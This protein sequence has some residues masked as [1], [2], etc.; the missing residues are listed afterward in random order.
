MITDLDVIVKEWAYKVHD[1][2][3][4]PK[5]DNHIYVLSNLLYELKWPFD[6]IQEL[7][8]NL[9]EEEVKFDKKEIPLLRNLGINKSVPDEDLA[10]IING[11]VNLSGVSC[12]KGPGTT[13]FDDESYNESKLKKILNDG[14]KF[15]LTFAGTE[16]N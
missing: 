7:L 11:K 4:N 15:T 10:D 14:S 3:P 2:K 9:T 13:A 12:L 5:N 1:G 8:H 6:S 16:K